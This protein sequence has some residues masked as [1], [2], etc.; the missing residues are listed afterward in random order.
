MS[1]N[2]H[3]KI[4]QRKAKSVTCFPRFPTLSLAGRCGRQLWHPEE[5][6]R[7][8]GS[9][10]EVTW[11]CLGTS[12][13]HTFGTNNLPSCW[14]QV[15]M[16]VYPMTMY[17]C[18]ILYWIVL[19]IS[20]VIVLQCIWMTHSL[21]SRLVHYCEY[22][23][24]ISSVSSLDLAECPA[25]NNQRPRTIEKLS[26]WQRSKLLRGAGWH[27][28]SS[29]IQGGWPTEPFLSL[30]RLALRESCGQ[31]DQVVFMSQRFAVTPGLFCRWW[32]SLPPRMA[33]NSWLLCHWS[34][35]SGE[36]SESWQGKNS[37]VSK[38]LIP[39][40]TPNKM[41][42]PFFAEADICLGCYSIITNPKS[43]RCHSI[44]LSLFWEALY[45]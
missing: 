43:K 15:Y 37:D 1:I 7:L 27:G 9:R 33:V 19:D 36:T 25:P 3:F 29:M 45:I 42:Q 17:I 31:V 34:S 2:I 35:K 8:Q 10:R 22:S 11:L 24:L 18:F 23:I 39:R 13:L 16:W 5:L 21:G 40:K 38:R 4:R 32:C 6:G 14:L 20:N 41:N 26:P 28:N 44:C 30:F 12:F